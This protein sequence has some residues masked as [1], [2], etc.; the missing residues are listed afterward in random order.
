MLEA[1]LRCRTLTMY[2]SI[3]EEDGGMSYP[4]DAAVRAA[5]I[6]TLPWIT[7]QEEHK[8]TPE[9]AFTR[10]SEE[11]LKRYGNKKKNG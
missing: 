9:E 8:E 6:R 3:D 10:K 7:I 5:K 4:T 2:P 11:W 1:D